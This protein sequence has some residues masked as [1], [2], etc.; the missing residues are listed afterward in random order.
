MKYLKLL[1]LKWIKRACPHICL[2]CK[3]KEE[4][5][6]DIDTL[7]KELEQFAKNNQ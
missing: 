1:W 3:C 4:C 6:N 2:L 5:Y 7:L